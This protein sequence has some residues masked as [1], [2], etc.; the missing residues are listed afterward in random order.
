MPDVL[1]KVTVPV[2]LKEINR[3][4]VKYS[5]YLPFQIWLQLNTLYFFKS[6]H[7]EL[8]TDFFAFKKEVKIMN[9]VTENKVALL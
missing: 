2:S 6:R 1:F 8:F 7:G 9:Y 3:D 5:F 4:A